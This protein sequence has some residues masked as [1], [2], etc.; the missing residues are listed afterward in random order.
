MNRDALVV[1]INKY[2]FLRYSSGAYRHLTTPAADAEAI[3]QLL[4]THGDFRVR[5]F[6]SVIIDGKLQVDPNQPFKTEELEQA[7]LDLFLPETQKLP[8]TALLFFSGHGLRKKL[9]QNLTQGFLAAS[10]ANPSKVWGFSL[11][12]LWEILQKSQV[13]QQII[14]LD[15]SFSGELLNFK[16]T[17]LGKQSS[18]CDRSFIAASRDYEV[19]YQQLDGKHGVLTG[20]LLSAL[21]PFQ[22]SEYDWI[23]NERL[24]VSIEQELQKYYDL[25]KIPQSSL[26][27]N[28]GKA[29]KLIQGKAKLNTITITK[30]EGLR[31]NSS[32]SIFEY[33][34]GGSLPI[35]APTYVRR[36]TDDELYQALK[37]GE[38]CYVLNSRQTGKS[39]LGVQTMQ[40]LQNE[41]IACAAIDLCCVDGTPEQ[42]YAGVIDNIASSLN[43]DNFDIDCWWE[44]NLNISLSQRFNEFIKKVL[45]AEIFNPIVIFFDEI[46]AINGLS[47]DTDDFLTFIRFCYNKRAENPE[48]TRLTFC[49]L[50]VASPSQ[51]ITDKKRTPFNIGRA[52]ELHGFQL[53]EA[54]PLAEGLQRQAND[55]QAVLSEVLFWTDGQPFLTQKLCQ[56]IRASDS[57]ITAGSEKEYITTLVRLNILENWESQDEP[58]HLRTIRD[59]VISNESRV[60]RLLELYREILQR[61]EVPSDNS[62][63]QIELQLSGLVARKQGKLSVYNPIYANVFNLNWV[64]E[65]LA[66]A[67]PYADSINA[68]VASNYQDESCL[69]RGQALQDA[70]AWSQGKELS[71]EDFRFLL[72]SQSLGQ[73]VVAESLN[74]EEG[75]SGNPLTTNTYRLIILISNTQLTVGQRSRLQVK[76]EP[77]TSNDENSFQIP[78]NIPELQCFVSADGLRVVDLEAA[79]I[80]IDPETGH[81]LA[82]SFELQG[83]LCGKRTFGVELF[84]EDPDSG[85]LSIF[86]YEGQIIV[87]RPRASEESL[88]I[89]SALPTLNISVAPQANFVLL[90]ETELP[91]GD[92]GSY[93]FTYY[94]TSR[95]RDLKLRQQEV[96]KVELQSHQLKRMRSLLARTVHFATNAKPEDAREQMVS[97]GCFLFDMLFPAETTAL[98]RDAFWQVADQISTWLII[99][100]GITWLPWELVVPYR[101]DNDTIPQRFL[102]ES[103][104]LSRWIQGLGIPLYNEVPLGE[105]AIAHYNV[106]DTQDEGI[107]AWKQ[108]LQASVTPGIRQAVNPEMPFYGLHLLRYAEEFN[109]RDIVARDAA[110]PDNALDEEVPKARLDLRLKRPIVTLS[111]IN[112]DNVQQNTGD[113][114]IV[115][116]VL[117]YLRVGASAVVGCCWQTSEVAERIFWSQFYELLAQ[118]FSLGEIVWRARLAVE[119]ALP[120]RLD[121]LAYTLFGDPC[122]K[123]YEPEVSSG[124]SVLECLNPDE[125]FHVGKTYYFRVSIRKRPPVWYKDK[126]IKTEELSSQLQALFMAPGLQTSFAE[127]VEMQP[128][129]RYMRQAT[130]SLNPQQEGNYP[131]MVQIL[132]GEELVK[133][134]QLNLKV[135]G[136]ANG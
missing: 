132:E 61:G 91:D 6:P 80:S 68:W 76:I 14:W 97:V 72:A 18:G 62:S 46:D 117:P 123:A 38:F 42:W 108:V 44:D 3:A 43:I 69:L 51:L 53:H 52:I 20:A 26:I 65:E 88:P 133:T 56:I 60:V 101:D 122:A 12:L 25:V 23:T 100:D 67:R 107:E 126:L 32:N 13:K 115:E 30:S 127:P 55:P 81:P 71:Q 128:T 33:Q 131:L 63:T 121:W 70:L 113:L 17:E 93:F 75:E 124:Y 9:R 83:Y 78:A 59:R 34:L 98:L 99:E 31:F 103:Y 15:C 119:R 41:G 54:L 37:A 112:N 110:K 96:G 66:K 45:L 24:A 125:P 87:N 120:H 77:A 84:V 8:E 47:F 85:K 94:L 2:P 86:K 11:Q 58:E 106:L 111:I 134:L 89:L 73:N 92:D 95:L 29:I 79:T 116:R 39:S 105:I 40:R 57:L 16:D 50:G 82:A 19:A 7:I 118:G 74:I 109:R 1:G 10:D 35:N 90:V 64:E 114:T 21:D 27:S 4:E 48:Y 130:L 22:A 5:R 49:L 104:F 28:Q 135:R 36:Q 102:C 129:G 136:Q